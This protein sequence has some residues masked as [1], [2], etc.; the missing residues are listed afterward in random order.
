[1]EE[2]ACTFVPAQVFIYC[3]VSL[4]GN[5]IYMRVMLGWCVTVIGS[6]LK[7][8]LFVVVVGIL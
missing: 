3:T 4:S 2:D 6:S 5:Y 8:Q 7:P 1:M